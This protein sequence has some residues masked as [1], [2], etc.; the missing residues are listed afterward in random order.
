MAPASVGGW[1][2]ERCIV[3]RCA[4]T[5][6]GTG[7]DP[8]GLLALLFL[9]AS[10]FKKRKNTVAFHMVLLLPKIFLLMNIT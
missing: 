5:C 10:A 8:R 1:G 4:V 3:M 7:S 2:E 6:A 9:P